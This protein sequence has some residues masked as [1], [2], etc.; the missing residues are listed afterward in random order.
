VCDPATLV[1]ASTIVASAGQL[2]SGAYA[3]Q[4]AGYAAQVAQ[5][6]KELSRE[7][8]QDA[9]VRGQEEQQRLGRETAQRVGS[10]RARLSANNVDV[11]FGSA[12]RVVDDTRDLAEDEA[13]VIAE[14][15]RR[16][17]RSFQIDAYGFESERRAALAE[18]KSAQIGTAF[19]VAST[20]LGGAT[21]YSEFRAKRRVG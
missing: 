7:S 5:Q 4:Q 16:Q 14:N 9:I 10:Q 11:G 12:A 18:R 21:Q 15:T 19:G 3:S 1:I 2:Y 20:A 13:N 17:V 8:A 6:N